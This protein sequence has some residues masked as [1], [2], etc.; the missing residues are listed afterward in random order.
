MVRCWVWPEDVKGF[1]SQWFNGGQGSYGKVFRDSLLHGIFW[2]IWKEMNLRLFEGKA[3][4]S[5]VTNSIIREVGSWVT[6]TK[7]FNGF[8]LSMILDG[9]CSSLVW[10]SL[11]HSKEALS[12]MLPLEGMLK[13]NF[14]DALKGNPSQA[15]FGYVPG[16]LPRSGSC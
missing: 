13:L 8:S 1:I 2:G 5:A 16:S 3:S 15:G 14:D 6:M 9:W 7:E 11:I 12:W 10:S 4:I